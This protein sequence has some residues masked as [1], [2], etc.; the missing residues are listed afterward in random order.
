MENIYTIQPTHHGRARVIALTLAIIL[1]LLFLAPLI[2]ELQPV[3]TK[4]YNEFFPPQTSGKPSNIPAFTQPRTTPAPVRYMPRPPVTQQQAPA[5]NQIQQPQTQSAQQQNALNSPQ[6]QPAEA[7]PPKKTKPL[8]P[9]ELPKIPERTIVQQQTP[10][11]TQPTE[12]TKLSQEEEEEAYRPLPHSPRRR[13]RERFY[14]NGKIPEQTSKINASPYNQPSAGAQIAQGFSQHMYQQQAYEQETALTSEHNTQGH[15]SALEAQL[16]MHNFSITFCNNSY[17][18]P[19][20]MH[21]SL[22]QPHRIELMITCNK[23]RKVTMVRFMKTSYDQNINEYI[24]E[25]LTHMLT[26]QIPASVVTP[27]ITF[28]ISIELERVYQSN[29]IYFVPGSS[30]RRGY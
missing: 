23:Q 5:Q 21:T 8:A 27:E 17:N 28:P 22:I 20:K 18:Q 2:L 3:L 25:L 14:K 15:D 16:F 9:K 12:Q 11:T 13:L 24:K 7:K 30:K 1:Y 29:T 19:L 26:P 4:K 10:Q 6:Q